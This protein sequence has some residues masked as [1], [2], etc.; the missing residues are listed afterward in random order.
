[1]VIVLHVVNHKTYHRGHIAD[2]LFQIPVQPPT[3]DLPVFLR[4]AG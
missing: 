4:V 1:V 3:T 2:M